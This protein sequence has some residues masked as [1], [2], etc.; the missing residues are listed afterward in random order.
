[1]KNTQIFILVFLTSDL[2][3]A[4]RSSKWDHCG[5]R[6]GSWQSWSDCT[7]SCG[8]GTHR[9]ERQVWNHN[10]PECEGFTACATGDM[11]FDHRACNNFCY[12]G[13]TVRSGY[14][15]CPDGWRGTCCGEKVTCGNPGTL[16]NGQRHGDAFDFGKTVTYTCRDQYNMT[17]GTSVRTCD[18]YG[19][20]TGSMPRCIFAQTCLSN[21]CQNGGTCVDGLDR[22][23]CLCLT[24]W[25]G[26]N[27]ERDIQPPVMTDCPSNIKMNVSKPTVRVNWTIPTFTDPMKT[28]LKKTHNYPS[29]HWEFPWGDYTVQYSAVK[30]SNGLR[31]ECVF[32]ITVRRKYR[33][34]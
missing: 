20:W 22:Y 1:M 17:R 31:T 3:I 21:P 30:P 6:W 12:N 32:N 4:G 16:T 23:S 14:C 26:I 13:G 28:T 27:C 8:G 2:V 11:A 19:R 18:K 34:H 9:R 29:N 33:K 15:R 24:G 10:W 7:R 25:S 5:C